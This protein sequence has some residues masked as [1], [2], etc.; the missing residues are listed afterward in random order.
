MKNNVLRSGYNA[1]DKSII[2]TYTIFLWKCIF[3]YWHFLIK[4]LSL[5]KHHPQMSTTHDGKMLSLIYNHHSSKNSSDSI[6]S[7]EMSRS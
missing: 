2:S 7:N 4:V 6:N 1:R 3:Y 5:I